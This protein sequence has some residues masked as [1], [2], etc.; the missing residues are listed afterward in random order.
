MKQ[1]KL[2]KIGSLN[3][4]VES[5]LID[6]LHFFAFTQIWRI[7]LSYHLLR[8]NGTLPFVFFFHVQICL[9][10]GAITE[11]LVCRISHSWISKRD[12][13]KSHE[14]MKQTISSKRNLIEIIRFIQSLSELHRNSKSEIWRIQFS[15]IHFE[16]ERENKLNL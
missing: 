13:I 9:N 14:S 4:G 5:S 15:V 10:A 12:R 16:R 3:F 1:T 11:D 7:K 6:P 2:N 8:L